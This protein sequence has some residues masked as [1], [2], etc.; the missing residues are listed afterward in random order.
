MIVKRNIPWFRLLLQFKGSSF[1]ETWPRILLATSIAIIVTYVEVR[2]GLEEYTLTTTPFTLIGVALGIVLGFRNNASYDRFWEARILWGSL[3]NTS[4]SLARQAYSLTSDETNSPE[5]NNFREAF[6]KRVIAFVHALRHHLRD[7]DPISDIT[8]F[9]APDDLSEV[10]HSTHR[11]FFVLHQLGREFA[12]AKEK[13]W[14]PEISVLAIDGQLV[15][16]SN[17]MGAC[18][19]IK[20]TPIPFTYTVLIHRIVAF[21]CFFLPFGLINTAG[22]LTP[23]VVFLISHAFF[24]LD[25]IGDEIGEP[26]G[27]LPNNLAL[28]SLSRTIEINLLELI[29]DP[30]RPEPEAPIDGVLY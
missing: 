25:A 28:S 17:I 13:R 18:E 29:N 30:N 14:L 12:K 4:R 2:Y 20:N 21:Y 5:L 23:V 19:R 16:L 15:E 11:P 26:F 1:L 9:L 8:R 10:K 6:V 22:I 27:T 3:V 24:G 7:S